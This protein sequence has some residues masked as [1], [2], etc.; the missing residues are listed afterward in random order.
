MQLH[1]PYCHPY[2]NRRL[3][4]CVPQS[5]LDSESN[6]IVDP[7]SETSTHD[8]DNPLKHDHR[9]PDS[10]PGQNAPHVI[11]NQDGRVDVGG[12]NGGAGKGGEI[13]AWASCGKVVALERAEYGEFV[14]SPPPPPSSA[15]SP[16]G[17]VLSVPE[18]PR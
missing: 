4:H 9:Y 1:R 11:G 15:S 12:E 14:V 7:D 17:G 3:V 13:P 18:H 6:S 16:D 5:H 2:G 8:P 10:S